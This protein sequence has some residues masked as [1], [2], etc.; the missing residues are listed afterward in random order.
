M[1][2]HIIVRSKLKRFGKDKWI[3]NAS[4]RDKLYSRFYLLKPLSQVRSMSDMNNNQS[5]INIEIDGNKNTKISSKQD[6]TGESTIGSLDI[7]V[8]KI[9]EISRHPDADKLYVEKI[10]VGEETT[11]T[12]ISGLVDYIPINELQN[13][14]VLV[15]C[16]LPERKMRGITSQGMVLASTN[17]EGGE[18]KV[19]LIDPPSSSK[20]GEKLQFGVQEQIDPKISSKKLERIM[21]KCKVNN[22][23]IAVYIND[24]N[25]EIQFVTSDG[26]CTSSLKNSQIS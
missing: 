21:K 25:Q 7:R 11:R 5:H 6:G 9:V 16:N 13:R 22:D 15:L 3:Q 2:R 4:K 26:V 24:E 18:R 17:D 23:G 14:L 10:D 1:I 12:I 19:V 8:G 20:V